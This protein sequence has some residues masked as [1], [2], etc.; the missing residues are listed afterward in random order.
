M[1]GSGLEHKAEGNYEIS[2][3]VIKGRTVDYSDFSI[4]SKGKSYSSNN[5]Y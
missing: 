2:P 4:Y 1:C 5:D 3:S